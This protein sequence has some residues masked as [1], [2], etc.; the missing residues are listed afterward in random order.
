MPDELDEED[1]EDAL[2]LDEEDV[3]ELDEDELE[4]DDELL[5]LDEDPDSPPHPTS[6]AAVAI[7]I[8][9]LEKSNGVCACFDIVDTLKFHSVSYYVCELDLIVTFYLIQRVYMIKR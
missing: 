5:E 9:T 2:E 8:P 6:N 7:A 1:D 4:L 3:L